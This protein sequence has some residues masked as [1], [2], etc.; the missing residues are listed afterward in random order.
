MRSWVRR[1]DSHRRGRAAITVAVAA[2]IASSGLPGIARAKLVFNERGQIV[3]LV[4]D[5][6]LIADDERIACGADAPTWANVHDAQG[7]LRRQVLHERGRLAAMR[8]FSP[9]GRIAGEQEWRVEP[10]VDGGSIVERWTRRTYDEAGRRRFETVSVA[11]RRVSERQFDE[12]GAEIR[13]T[14]WNARGDKT[15]TAWYP[16]RVVARQEWPAIYEGAPARMI[17]EYWDNG[18]IR[19]RGTIDAQDRRLGLFQTFHR[20]AG[21]ASESFYVAGRL[22]RKREFDER[23]RLVLEEEYRDDGSPG[24]SMRR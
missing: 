14:R 12:A 24:T 2:A 17:Q 13:S 15:E 22:R 9:D 4:C 5:P 1:A 19:S 23:G 6:A 11:G 18:Q 20:G 10:G 7:R 8:E 21:L 3:E 16:N